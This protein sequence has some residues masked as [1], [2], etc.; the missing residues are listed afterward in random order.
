VVLIVTACG[1]TSSG[2]STSANHT[3][4][5]TTIQQL[6]SFTNCDSSGKPKDPNLK[7]A[8][9]ET[10]LNTP[11]RV[12]SMSTFQ[13]W[14][15]KLC[16]PHFIWNQANENVSTELNNVQTLL[17]QQPSVL[18]LDPLATDPLTPVVTLANSAHVPLIVIDRA[19][20]VAPG[21]GTYQLFIGAQ[22]FPIGNLP[23]LKWI[24]KLKAVQKTDSPKAN[25]V[26]LDGGVGQD[27][28]IER[29]NGVAT[30]I[31]PYPN[32]H[33]VAAE[34]GDWTL[35]GGRQVMEAYLQRY[36]VGSLQG[37]YAASDEMMLGALE[38]LQAAHRTDL[39][40]W[41]FTGDGQLQGLQQIVA[42]VNIADTQNPPFYGQP[43]LEAAIA[44][45]QGVQFHAQTMNLE[46]KT[47]TCMTAA[48]CQ[49]TKAYIATITQENSLF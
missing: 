5:P 17:A 25:L 19:L 46:N 24:E 39:N 32:I 48:E 27:P 23:A 31:K 8:F 40:G 3:P 15:K 36:P 2:A 1:G 20:S 44:I 7:I 4:A 35:Q 37:V 45:S 26:L 41:F 38:A 29:H 34:S 6:A 28:A 9:A 22:Q 21:Q 49:A 30:A 42:G 12:T 10:D 43:S 14:A 33:L 13:T 18:I 16:V 11:W 47:F